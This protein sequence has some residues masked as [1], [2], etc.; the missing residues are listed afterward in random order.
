M[1]TALVEKITRLVLLELKENSHSSLECSWND[2]HPST[3]VQPNYRPLTEEELKKWNAISSSIGIAQTTKS[4]IDENPKLIPL[5]E[6]ELKV[7]EIISSSIGTGKNAKPSEHEHAPF[8][9]EDPQHCSP[10]KETKTGMYMDVDKDLRNAK[11]KFF[12]HH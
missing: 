1:N 10:K 2:R 8:S 3:D 12:R 4:S 9:D 5:T 6:E 7:W 11:V